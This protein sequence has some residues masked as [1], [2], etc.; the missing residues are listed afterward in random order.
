MIGLTVCAKS[1]L[2]GVVAED[3]LAVHMGLWLESSRPSKLPVIEAASDPGS[4]NPLASMWEP[5]DMALMV[6]DHI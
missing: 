6:G 1:K 4:M 3:P 2:T 5:W